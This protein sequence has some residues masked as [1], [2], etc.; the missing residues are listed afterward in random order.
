LI[1]ENINIANESLSSANENNFVRQNNRRSGARNN[2]PVNTNMNYP[3]SG[4]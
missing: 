4:G 1:N 2:G 3:S